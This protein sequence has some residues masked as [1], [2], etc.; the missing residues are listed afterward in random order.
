MLGDAA[1][2]GINEDQVINQGALS[3][4]SPWWHEIPFAPGRGTGGSARH[5]TGV[6]AGDPQGTAMA[7]LSQETKAGTR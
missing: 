6:R 3:L 4:I 5:A 7:T 1:T 2:L